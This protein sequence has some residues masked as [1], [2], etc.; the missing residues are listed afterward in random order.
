MWS[1]QPPNNPSQQQL[2]ATARQIV[3]TLQ[4]EG[5]ETYWAGG[6]VRDALLHQP[7]TDYDIATAAHPQQ[8]LQIFPHAKA[9]GRSFGVVTVPRDGENFEVATFRADHGTRDGRHPESISF[10][11]ARED[12]FRRDF[13]INAM[14]YD[15]IAGTL[16]DFVQGQQDLQARCLRCVGEPMQR[17]TED[18]L[19]MMRAV[20]FT[21]R[22]Q[23]EM[24]PAT[25]EAI[26][27]QAHLLAAISPERIRDE[28]VK[29]LLEAQRPG[30]ALWMLE[31][32]GLLP[33]FL[34]EVSA[35]K[36]QDQ[37]P[38]FHPEGDVFTHTALMLDEMSTRDPVLLFAVLLH[39]IAKPATAQTAS[40]RI[41]FHGHASLGS[42]MAHDILTR[43][44]LPTRIIE[45]VCHCV[46]GHMRFMEVKNMRRATLRKLIGHPLF[47]VELELH[48]L[49]CL[50]CH[51]M[52]DNYTFVRDAQAAFEQEPCLPAPWITG[53]DLIQMGL[54][55]GPRFGR[56]LKQ[57]YDLQ[58]DGTYPRRE[59]LLDH[60]RNKH[61]RNN[62]NE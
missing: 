52:L 8:V 40:D 28:F 49:D 17:F 19:R 50:A 48:R 7:P 54:K 16:H 25:A 4:T 31:N 62:N 9:V 12:A 59:E 38:A 36:E 18:H 42:R 23:F 47:P 45:A 27:R 15:P 41:R 29:T 3:A 61:S 11:S 21:Q 6:C 60:I 34:P 30:Q 2:R 24:H 44:R 14:F 1:P 10:V 43:L 32:L 56:I 20:R 55:P 46:R 37:P 58:L 26:T 35:L 22:L 13:T 57:A 53:Q 5:Y 51:G 39:D 33:V